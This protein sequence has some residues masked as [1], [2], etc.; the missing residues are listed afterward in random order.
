MEAIRVKR[1]KSPEKTEG[2][3]L[4]RELYST[5]PFPGISRPTFIVGCGRS[6]TTILGKSLS[7]HKDVTYLNEP[8]HLWF[9]AFPETDI[10]TSGSDTRHGKLS[11]RGE[12]VDTG[13]GRKLSRLFRFESM[14]RR[15]PVLIEKLPIN[16][17]RLEFIHRIF[18]DA[19]FVHIFRNGL[20]VARS[21]EKESERGEWF[22]AH[23]YKWQQLA[24]YAASREETRDLPALCTT[25]R[26]MGLLEW[27]LST[28]AVVAFLA[29]LPDDAYIEINYDEFVAQPVETI[30]QL[31]RFVG[32]DEDPDVEAFVS[33]AVTRKST[34]QNSATLSEKERLLGGELLPLSMDGGKGLTRRSAWVDPEA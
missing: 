20:E 24:D 18:P 28:E 19:R 22:G 14:I 23:S 3:G 5:L 9:S 15:R 13:K 1:G 10:W 30:A 16:A 31:Q 29:R 8:R 27:R 4:L 26:E 12:D 11:F 21:I 33:R 6:G 34:K 17:F 7:R 25:Y 32:V 2:P